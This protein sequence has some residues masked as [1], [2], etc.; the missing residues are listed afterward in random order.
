M[1]I[2]QEQWQD[3]RR[4]AID[5]LG[6]SDI[7]AS[8]CNLNDY[9]PAFKTWLAHDYH[10]DMSYM[11]K[12]G[13]KRYKPEQ[14]VENTNSVI[15]VRLNYLPETYSFKNLRQK[16]KMP[17]AIAEISRYALGRDYHKVIRHKLKKLNHYIQ[18]LLPE[19][20]G[21]V[22]TDSAPVLEKPLAEK[23]GLGFIGKNSNLIDTH[24]GSFFFLGTIYSNLDFSSFSALKQEDGCGGCK[25]CIKSCPTDAIKDGRLIDAR[26][27]IS[28]LTIENK[29]AIPIEFRSA[30]GNRIYGCDDCQLVC[31]FNR[32]SSITGEADFLPRKS[33]AAK[34]L[35]ELIQWNQQTFY[36]NTE[37]SPIRRIGFISWQRNIIVALGNA[38]Q[39]A[40][41]LTILK[42]KKA[43]EQNPMLTE[44][45]L[46]AIARQ[47]G[48]I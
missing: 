27:C 40:E 15:M 35:L 19:H 39:S 8:D 5:Y 48:E 37:G 33:L 36:D 34:S 18:S 44:H 26:R 23:S 32:H 14:L 9:I 31:P 30:I 12:H 38:P 29:G 21:R 2:T 10:A 28:Y 13:S 24:S 43:I 41:I 3:I 22:F 6:F 17:S 16:L 11:H 46:W 25:A 42:A 20:Q 7:A 45:L 1:T 47:K 4:F